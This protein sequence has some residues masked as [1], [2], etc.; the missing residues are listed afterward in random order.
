MFGTTLQI[1]APLFF[2][3]FPNF[4]TTQARISQRKP[5]YNTMH[6]ITQRSL[7]SLMFPGVYT[8]LVF[9]YCIVFFSFSLFPL[10]FSLLILLLLVDIIIVWLLSDIAE[11]M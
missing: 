6:A 1:E 8:N 9:L 5:L 11:Y 4:L 3:R 7:C 2:W 10:I